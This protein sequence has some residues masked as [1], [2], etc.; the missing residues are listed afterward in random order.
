M[1]INWRWTR[2][3][4]HKMDYCEKCSKNVSEMIDTTIKILSIRATMSESLFDET[5]P[6]LLRKEN[7]T[8][9]VYFKKL[10]FPASANYS[11]TKQM[12]TTSSLWN[13]TACGSRKDFL[14]F[15]FASSRKFVI[16]YLSFDN[17]RIATWW[18]IFIP[19][20]SCSWTITNNY[21]MIEI[22]GRSASPLS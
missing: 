16:W 10:F 5:P 12:K 2:H 22:H 1:Q 18:L 14:S 17:E 13:L 7:K 6:K 11:N 3:I 15:S 21:S 8:I 20:P 9:R 4:K 19:H